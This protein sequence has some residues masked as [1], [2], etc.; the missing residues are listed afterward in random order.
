VGIRGTGLG[1]TCCWF[2]IDVWRMVWSSLVELVGSR[3]S[4]DGPSIDW[5]P[6]GVGESLVL[7]GR[8]G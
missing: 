4:L 6:L 3:L 1:T 8:R 7:L 2:L 5:R